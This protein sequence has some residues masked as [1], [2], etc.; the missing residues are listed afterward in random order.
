MQ[1]EEEEKEGE[2]DGDEGRGAAEVAPG[3]I[4]A[5]GLAKVKGQGHGRPRGGGRDFALGRAGR[6]WAGA[7]RD[8][9]KIKRSAGK[10][11]RRLRGALQRRGDAARPRPPAFGD[12][13]FLG[14]LEPPVPPLG[15]SRAR[16][17]GETQ[18]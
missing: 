15:E 2:E 13:G 4:N 10:R 16:R 3:A 1:E 6:P 17:G 11:R 8:A 5:P 9:A 14:L 18:K 7:N 12:A